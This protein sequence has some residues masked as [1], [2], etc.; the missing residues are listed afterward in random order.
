MFRIS[1]IFFFLSG[2]FFFSCTNDI[3]EVAAITANTKTPSQT[4]D[5]VTMLYTDSAKLRVMVKANRML[6]YDRNVSEPFTVMPKGF[7]VTLF[8]EEEKISATLKGKFGVR[9][10]QS[11]RMEARYDV[12][13]VNTKGEKLET[14][15]LVWD[16]VNNRIY[17]DAFVKITTDK[18]VITGKGLESNQD[19]SVYEIKDVTGIFQINDGL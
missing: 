11:K 13:V 10:D 16:E 6:I 15:R 1:V 18:E 4:G 5:S 7:F 17:T 2:Y 19:F 12:V 14:E 8:D 9:F 3:R